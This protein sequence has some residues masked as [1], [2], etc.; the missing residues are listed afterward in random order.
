MLE[1]AVSYDSWKN[2]LKNRLIMNKVIEEELASKITIT[3][4][5]V[6]EYYQ[7][8]YQGKELD[9]ES[10]QSSNDINEAIVKQL[11]R[12]KAE[13]KYQ[14]WIET[15]KAKYDI[16]VNIKLWEKLTGSK[17]IEENEKTVGNDPNSG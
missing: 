5:D 6:T 2:R 3:P 11:R 8:H 7:E 1:F 17:R 12:R 13:E 16:E 15:L 4:K 10:G 14:A 9:S